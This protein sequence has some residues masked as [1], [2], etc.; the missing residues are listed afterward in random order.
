MMEK[1]MYG[2]FLC[3]AAVMGSLTSNFISS[4]YAT[5]ASVPTKLLSECATQFV[6][7]DR[8][9]QG[10]VTLVLTFEGETVMHVDC[11]ASK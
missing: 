10:Q 8:H 1:Y 5:T 4:A 7:V 3:L 6:A 9:L 11:A 2:L